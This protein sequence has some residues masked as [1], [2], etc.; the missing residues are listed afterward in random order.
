VSFAPASAAYVNIPDCA[1]ADIS[2]GNTNR[3]APVQP[4]AVHARLSALVAV[5]TLP[6]T[7]V[8][9]FACVD[10]AATADHAPPIY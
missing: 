1:F 6:A 2:K 7:V 10:P 5:S 8:L 9:E 3:L 4:V